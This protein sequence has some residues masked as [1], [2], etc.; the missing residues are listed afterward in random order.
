MERVLVGGCASGR[1]GELGSSISPVFVS[2]LVSACLW[3]APLSTQVAAQSKNAQAS[4]SVESEYKR[5]LDQ[6]LSEFRLGNW[7]EARAL[8]ERAHE[9]S[10]SARTLR[11][12]GLSA[13]EE[14]SYAAA[15]A[16]L[17]A[18]LSDQ[19]RPLSPEQRKEADDAIK[20]SLNYVAQYELEIVPGDVEATVRVD[21]REPIVLDGRLLL[22][23]G[24]YA[25]EVSAEGYEI[26]RKDVVARP[27]EKLK[28]RIEL[29]PRGSD[30]GVPIATTVQAPPAVTQPLSDDEGGLTTQQ[31]IGVGVGAAGVVTL[32]VSAYFG[33]TAI[34][35]ADDADCSDGLC[36]DDRS[37][38]L[39][40][41]ALDAGTISTVTFVAGAV[42]A[43]AGAVLFFVPF[44]SDDE[45]AG[46]RLRPALAP[47]HA[48][49][50][51]GGRW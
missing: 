39:N 10:P 21:S 11:A 38:R 44:S 18:G 2:A 30:D 16:Y 5:L 12:M 14:K 26:S 4:D 41:Q 32:G 15:I 13:F 28:L 25:L 20:R 35:K 50:E 46:A 7:T 48:G 51:L 3:L 24:K 22:D 43:G 36:P 37:K 17:T 6:A 34:S 23:P 40:D 19:R 27:R 47:G 9:I 45:R 33:L 1:S 29:A 8:F 49:V 42:M 31:W